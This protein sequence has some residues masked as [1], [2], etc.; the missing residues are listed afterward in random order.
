VPGDLALRIEL[1]LQAAPADRWHGPRQPRTQRG[2]PAGHGI[3]CFPDVLKRAQEHISRPVT[4]APGGDRLN[5]RLDPGVAIGEQQILLAGEV[6]EESAGADRGR[7]RDVGDGCLLITAALEQVRGSV[8][9]SLPGA[10]TLAL[11]QGQALTS[12]CQLWHAAS[13]LRLPPTS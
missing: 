5:R 8:D 1:G 6:A 3:L 13:I 9:E 11:A 12:L 4:G 2:A 10:C 7:G